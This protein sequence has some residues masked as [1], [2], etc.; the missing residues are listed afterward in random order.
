MKK[1]QVNPEIL[2]YFDFLIEEGWK[3]RV[4]PLELDEENKQ[5]YRDR[6]KY[7]RDTLIQK[8]FI[9]YMLIVQEYV[10]WAKDRD[11]LVG[12][13]RGSAAGSLVA[14]L[15]KITD[16]DPI[17]YGLLFERFLNPATTKYD[18]SFEEYPITKW[19]HEMGIVDEDED[20]DELE[21]MV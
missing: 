15:L 3:E 9:D 10:N 11:I 14:Y 17:K 21:E 2:Q 8:G 5:A 20:E 12:A 1:K 7:E 6:V 16:I 4:S 18:F 19:K 13:G